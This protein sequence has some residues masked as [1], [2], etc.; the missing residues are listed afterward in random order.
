[1]ALFVHNTPFHFFDRYIAD[2]YR[3]MAL[4][5][6]RMRR[7]MFQLVPPEMLMIPTYDGVCS[8]LEP[9]VPVVDENGERKLK[10][11]FDVKN[12]KP[13]EVKVKMLGN[14][15]LQ[16]CAEHEESNDEG[17]TRRRLFVRQYRLPKGVD[18]EHLRPSL[19]KDGVLTIEAPAPGLAPSERLVPIQY[20]ADSA[21]N[22][23]AAVN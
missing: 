11:E 9:S 5:M 18:V 2:Y 6:E 23:T 17:A 3:Q 14:N 4:E 10:M 7:Q 8:E 21:G 22:E 13:E 19:S 16:V 12:F 20:Q 1:M 15:V